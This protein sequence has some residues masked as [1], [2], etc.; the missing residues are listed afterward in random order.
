MNASMQ[1]IIL[2]THDLIGRQT[3]VVAEEGDYGSANATSFLKS[4]ISIHHITALVASLGNKKTAGELPQ[5]I[6]SLQFDQ[7][8]MILHVLKLSD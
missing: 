8:L 6:S 5:V 1:G 7:S 3:D 4:I 2:K